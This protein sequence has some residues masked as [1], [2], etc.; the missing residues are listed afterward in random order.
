MSS[1]LKPKKTK[2]KKKKSGSSRTN[3]SR[4]LGEPPSP[5]KLS[6]SRR[7]AASRPSA[8]SA[9]PSAASQK[10]QQEIQERRSLNAPRGPTAN[11]RRQQQQQHYEDDDVSEVSEG[12]PMDL[13]YAGSVDDEPQFKYSTAELAENS[14]RNTTCCI[15]TIAVI[16]LALAIGISVMAVKL[17]NKN[18]EEKAPAETAPTAAPGSGGS[19][20]GQGSL[21][22]SVNTVNF[23]CADPSSDACSATCTDFLSCCDPT[24]NTQAGCFFGNR[25]G[26]LDHARC[27]TLESGIDAPGPTLDILCAKSR[28]ASDPSAC[29]A[30]CGQVKCCWD[31]SV[32]GDSPSPSC[33][34]DSFYA[35]IDYLPCQNLRSDDVLTVPPPLVGL[36]EICSAQMGSMSQV[37]ECDI[38]C[39]A[40]E[41]CWDAG[42]TNCLQ[43]NFF[44]CLA[45]EPCG[46]LEFPEA[47]SEVPNPGASLSDLCSGPFKDEAE[48]E[49]KCNAGACCN[50]FPSCFDS[51][52]L[53]CLAYEPCKNLL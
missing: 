25:Q 33:A 53:G 27:H 9:G 15:I 6:S 46:K 24:M 21:S 26:C 5:T 7:S 12:D 35:C 41:C 14:P 2:T 8:A 43:D 22:A 40:A 50:G 10:R 28:V 20:A 32:E 34:V 19:T 23:D 51:D 1:E 48:C 17:V 45:Y 18:D 30:A 39:K 29:D 37:E 47:F 16:C 11:S 36:P 3:L 52:P 42:V 13:P 4:N 38:A 31:D 44:T 49:S